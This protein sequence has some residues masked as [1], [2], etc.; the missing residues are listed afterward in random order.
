[1]RRFIRKYGAMIAGITSGFDR[2]VF[3]GTIRSL[4]YVKGMMRYLWD[5]QVLLTDFG[6]HV[7]SVSERVK[8]AAEA[9]MKRIGRPTKYLPSSHT[10]KELL[11]RAIAQRDGVKDGVI[12]MLSCVEPCRSYEVYRNAATKRLELQPRNRKCLFLYR[13]MQHPTFGFMHVRLQTWFPFQ[14]Q[15]CLNGREWQARQMD[16]AGLGYWRKENCFTALEDSAAAQRLADRQLRVNWAKE[17]NAL[18]L[19][20][21]PL[22]PALF[23]AYRYYWSVYQNEYATD[24]M[25]REAADLARLYPRW[26][27]HGITALGCVDVMRFL[28]RHVPT[29]GRIHG[30][31]QGQA[32]SSLRTRP[33]GTRLKHHVNG[34]SLKM[35][36]KQGNDLRVETTMDNVRDFKVF[37]RPEGQPQAPQ[38]WRP[39]RKGIADLQRRAHLSKASNQRYLD[40][41][42][43]IDTSRTIRELITPLCRPVEWKQH[44]V[45]ALRPLAADDARLLQVIH[46]GDYVLSGFRNR[47]LRAALYDSPSDDS[48]ERK[49]RA[50]KVTRLIR[51]LRAHNLIHKTTG[52]HR[53]MVTDKGREAITALLTVRETSLSELAKIAA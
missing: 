46:R 48:A 16:R 40:A 52:T 3:R 7:E 8:A 36:D 35:Y 38:A 1:M 2:L 28:G 29:T 17:L 32:G 10:D 27:R 4:S 23:G 42:A 6:V 53:Y 12:V 33:E 34:N 30:R 39:L 47:D 41:L 26:V 49:R 11:A 9:D 45:R 44:R 5:Q 15:V 19:E 14:V 20:I 13:Y 21:H 31:F 25:F 37:R 50:A 18:M 22:Y 43:A 51:M 24:V